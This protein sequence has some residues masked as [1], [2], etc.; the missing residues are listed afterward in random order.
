MTVTG[1][2]RTW[3]RPRLTGSS[4]SVGRTKPVTPAHTARRAPT[5]RRSAFSAAR[6]PLGLSGGVTIAA[7]ER[8][9][10]VRGAREASDDEL[11]FAARCGDGEA[12]AVFYERHVAAV[13]A[14][15]RPG[16]ALS[17]RRRVTDSIW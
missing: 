4:A 14:F 12:F 2:D 8:D 6:E 9:T 16:V 13:V 7:G 3:S 5:C 10:G 1:A 17:P 15:V 11:L